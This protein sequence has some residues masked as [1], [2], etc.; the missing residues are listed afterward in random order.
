M[1]VYLFQT[2]EEIVLYL[3]RVIGTYIDEELLTSYLNELDYGENK[4]TK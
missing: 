1:M 3:P 2:I 4:K